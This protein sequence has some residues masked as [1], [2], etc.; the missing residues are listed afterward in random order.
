MLSLCRRFLRSQAG[1]VAIEYNVIAT[2]IAIVASLAMLGAT[3][4]IGQVLFKDVVITLGQGYSGVYVSSAPSTS[5]PQD[6]ETASSASAGSGDSGT[7]E[8]GS[9]EAG[10]GTQTCSRSISVC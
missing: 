5:L 9:T 3:N 4:M 2:G 6:Y 8:S 1:D 7:Q 10:T